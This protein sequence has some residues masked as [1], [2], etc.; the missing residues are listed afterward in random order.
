VIPLLVA[1]YMSQLDTAERQTA[2]GKR[3]PTSV[4][5]QKMLM[6]HKENSSTMDCLSDSWV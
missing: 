2:A 3:P 6:W 5:A 4:A 1:R